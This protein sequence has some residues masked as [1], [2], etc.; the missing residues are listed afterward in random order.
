[1]SHRSTFPRRLP[2]THPRGGNFC[3]DLFSSFVL[4]FFFFFFL[5]FFFSNLC[6]RARGMLFRDCLLAR[7][8]LRRVLSELSDAI[9]LSFSYAL[10]LSRP[11]YAVYFHPYPTQRLCHP[12]LTQRLLIQRQ[13]THPFLSKSTYTVFLSNSTRTQRGLSRHEP[14]LL[15]TPRRYRLPRCPCPSLS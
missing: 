15:P 10:F 8:N 6:E 14:R 3:V 4:Y 2:P 13:L 1:M 7:A 11:F 12:N 5:Y 9:F